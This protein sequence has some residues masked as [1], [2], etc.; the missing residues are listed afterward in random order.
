VFAPPLWPFDLAGGTGGPQNGPLI[1]GTKCLTEACQRGLDKP[2]F[3][4]HPC[5]LAVGIEFPCHSQRLQCRCDAPG[6]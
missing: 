3:E 2:G 1:R 4:G 5:G 6:C